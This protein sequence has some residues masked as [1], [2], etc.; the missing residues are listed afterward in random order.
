MASRPRTLVVLETRNYQVEKS[1]KPLAAAGLSRQAIRSIKF[2]PAGIWCQYR[3]SVCPVRQR[4][5][6]AGV[7][8]EAEVVAQHARREAVPLADT[9]AIWTNGEAGFIAAKKQIT[10]KSLCHQVS[11]LQ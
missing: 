2:S 10:C 9:L 4:T 6:V 5:I 3:A 7:A 8:N 1:E 11:A